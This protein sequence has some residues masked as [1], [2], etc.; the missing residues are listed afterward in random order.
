MTNKSGTTLF[1]ISPNAAINKRSVR[2]L[3]WK[4]VSALSL[5]QRVEVRLGD[6]K[7]H[8]YEATQIFIDEAD[9]FEAM[10]VR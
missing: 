5:G 2:S 7:L 10:G 4:I 9:H 3:G 6:N 8:G 1:I